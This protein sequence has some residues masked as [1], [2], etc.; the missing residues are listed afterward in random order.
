VLEL[1]D[2]GERS[3]RKDCLVDMMVTIFEEPFF[4]V[5]RTKEQLAYSV[6]IM[7]ESTDGSISLVLM[8]KCQENKHSARSIATRLLNFVQ[9]DMAE[10]LEKLSDD[11]FDKIKESNINA[12]LIPF[13]SLDAESNFY[14]TQIINNYYSFDRKDKKAEMYRKISKHDIIYFYNEMLVQQ[15]HRNL[16][17]QLI[18]NVGE[19]DESDNDDMS[20]QFIDTKFEDEEDEVITN[21]EAF[22]EGLDT[23]PSFKTTY[24][25]D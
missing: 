11:D 18:G 23:Y 22:K 7:Y 2:L 20:L 25:Y 19:A 1:F 12:Q 17:I 21:M 3:L 14:F 4:D 16:S 6:T 24:H 5:L 10:I 15:P 13:T 9:A 8:I